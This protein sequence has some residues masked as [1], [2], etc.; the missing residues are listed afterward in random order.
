MLHFIILHIDSLFS[1]KFLIPWSE[2]TQT[3]AKTSPKNIRDLYLFRSDFTTGGDLVVGKAVI[4]NDPDFLPG[5]IKRPEK[6]WEI[7]SRY[8][9]SLRYVLI[10]FVLSLNFHPW[11]SK[12]A[13]AAW[14]NFTKTW[15]LLLTPPCWW[16]IQLVCNNWIS[17]RPCLCSKFSIFKMPWQTLKVQ[18][19]LSVLKSYLPLLRAF[20]WGNV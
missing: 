5:K 8:V 1:F 11:L 6:C 2:K 3:K 10:H 9:N 16:D 14:F 17:T 7:K 12:I 19:Q 20:K 4:A 18:P 15:K 13:W